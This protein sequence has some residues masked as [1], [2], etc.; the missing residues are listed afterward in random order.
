MGTVWEA[1]DEALHRPVAV[2]EILLPHGI[3]TSE[4]DELRER[5]MRE[6]RATAVLSHP[7]VVT[8][9]DI[10]RENGEPFVVMELVPGRSLSQI[11]AETP[12]LTMEQA[13]VVADAVA[14]ALRAAHSAGIT[15]RDVKPGNVLVA[16]DGRIKLTDF[17][18]ARNVAEQTM[19]STGIMLG[20]PAYIAP[21]VAAG[22]QVTPMA[23]LWGLGAT[24]FTAV[25]GRTPYDPE[26]EVLQILYQVVNGEVPRPQ[27]TGPL[28]EVITGLMVR[29]PAQRMPL[30]ELRRKIYGLLPEPGKSVFG[31]QEK[32]SQSS[33]TV[34]VVKPGM[35]T[36]PALD[37]GPD[38]S[39]KREQ[40]TVDPRS[41]V[42]ASASM[43]PAAAAANAPLAATPGPLPF[44]PP[45]APPTPPITRPVSAAVLVASVLLFLVATAGGFALTR[46]LAGV[47]LLP[48]SKVTG[49]PP[50]VSLTN[51]T[52][53][54][55]VKLVPRSDFTM[56]VPVDWQRFTEERV[57]PKGL[58]TSAR[59][60]YVSPDGS[61]LLAVER[62]PGFYPKH[63]I[64]DYRDALKATLRGVTIRDGDTPVAN[65]PKGAERATEF[66]FDT[67][68]AGELARTTFVQAIPVG[69]ED[70]WVVS[71]TVPTEAEQTRRSELFDQIAATFA[72][73]D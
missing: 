64:A 56:A 69:T 46:Q 41:A 2:K 24:L 48:T 63:R 35:A 22:E 39:R 25:E 5:M 65:R 7:N 34:P 21:E 68:E 60:Q 11:L 27:S 37:L 31:D 15:H 12:K 70:L 42:A 58:P 14:S 71:L 57:N 3:P 29:E 32:G 33:L 40:T 18:I 51:R 61:Y 13:A 62:F 10:A 54:V 19:T 1:Y 59:T 30:V 73:P 8:L 38:Q 47:T 52:D 66:V 4:A 9:Y 36:V 55:G 53:T 44:T 20:S 72:I 67:T 28:A 23:D 26:L 16:D 50:N 43:A 45:P 17:G 6:A 49:Q